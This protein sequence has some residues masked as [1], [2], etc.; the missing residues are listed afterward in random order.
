[1][2]KDL[3]EFGT[4]VLQCQARALADPVCGNQIYSNGQSC[5]CVLKGKRCDLLKSGK[6]NSVFE[7]KGVANSYILYFKQRLRCGKILLKVL[8]YIH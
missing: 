3:A 7:L 1:L 4:N 5:R 2:R 8:V 6:G